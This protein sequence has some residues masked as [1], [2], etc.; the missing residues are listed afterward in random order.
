MGSVDAT[1][2]AHHL[3]EHGQVRKRCI[4]SVGEPHG[5]AEVRGGGSTRIVG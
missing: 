3:L 1:L 4:R 2:P 5:K